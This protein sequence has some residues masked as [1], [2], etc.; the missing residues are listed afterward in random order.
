MAKYALCMGVNDYSQW[1]G[2]S[3]LPYSV[4][5]A[6]DFAQI[7]TDGLDFEPANV[8]IMRDAWCTK[9][10]ILHAID[11]LLTRAQAGDVVCVYYSGHG[12]RIQGVAPSGQ[13]EPD[14]W[15]EAFLP[16]SGGL[17]TDRELAALADKL[18]YDHVNFTLVLDTC[19]SGGLHPVEGAPHPVGV[20]IPESLNAVFLSACR[21]LVPAGLCLENPRSDIA[22][23]VRTIRI[24]NGHL[25]IEADDDSHFVPRAK[26]TLISAC[27]ADQFGWHVHPLQN[28][29]LVGAFKNVINVSGF[30]EAYADLLTLLR[31]AADQLM[32]KY[33]RSFAQFAS[34]RSVPQLYGQRARMR[35][36]FMAPW[37][38]SIEG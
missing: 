9:G 2:A 7:L 4:K 12:T 26:S 25:V 22:G 20:P 18:E 31:G 37:T 16:Y 30:R 33:V 21:A 27:A 5:S 19:H 17:I 28:T 36:G 14:R 6:E 38:F 23:N 13:P 24:E 10:N 8:S 11:G 35:E 3:N 15:Y 34:M 29:I 32:T 1:S